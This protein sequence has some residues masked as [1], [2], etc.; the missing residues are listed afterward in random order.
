MLLF[1][2]ENAFGVFS[3]F[4]GAVFSYYFYLKSLK[5]KAIS[6]R[7]LS[8]TLFSGRSAGDLPK[9]EIFYDRMAISNIARTRLCVWNS[10]NEIVDVNDL[11]SASPLT[12]RASSSESGA[13]ICRILDCRLLAS[14]R[15]ASNC[16]AVLQPSDNIIALGF[17]YLEA[18]E[19]FVVDIIHSQKAKFELAGAVKGVKS[20]TSNSNTTFDEIV[21]GLLT[22]DLRGGRRRRS[23]VF[24]IFV[25][26]YSYLS[27]LFMIVMGF[28]G[29]LSSSACGRFGVVC[30]S[31]I[32]SFD[33]D[34]P[35]EFLGWI[36]GVIGIIGVV[37][38]VLI[39]KA[40]L[41][42]RAPK[43]LAE[44]LYPE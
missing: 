10:G 31:G 44:S 21:F 19:G 40:L 25:S 8:S 34:P 28:G 14:S 37:G 32:S 26:V 13:E 2:Q 3:L 1:V 42:S 7:S 43:E 17:D 41:S 29:F 15:N 23:R 16:A 39:L 30:H 12:V 18:N 11:V 22:S 5:R 4:I 36:M 9:L 33:K 38:L 35:P 27:V 6:Y 20:F 24:R